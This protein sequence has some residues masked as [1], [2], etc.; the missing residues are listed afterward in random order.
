[1]RAGFWDW[2]GRD[3]LSPSTKLRASISADH[4]TC[5]LDVRLLPGKVYILALNENGIPGVGFQNEKGFSL[6]PTFL[7]FQTAGTPA[8]DDAP[9]GVV[10]TNPANGAQR[11]DTVRVRAVSVT[12]DKAMQVA[13]H[14]LHMR[15]NQKEV[16]LSKARFQY[17]TDGKSFVL[18]YDFK[19]ASTY[20]FELN[21]VHDIGFASAKRVP[22][23]PGKFAF[24]TQ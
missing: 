19:P 21:S 8:P 18:A 4:L 6:P 7:V 1:M 13:K 24:S 23:W 20:E 22:L 9:P 14:G 3:V 5:T 2:L 11:I 16:D 15:E 17:A 10:T 12:F